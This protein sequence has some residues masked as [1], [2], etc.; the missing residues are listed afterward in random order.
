MAQTID[1]IEQVRAQL[2]PLA[3]VD[4]AADLDFAIVQSIPTALRRLAESTAISDAPHIRNYFQKIFVCAIIGNTASFANHL[5]AT[6]PMLLSV[7][8]AEVT[9]SL[10]THPFQYVGGRSL[11]TFSGSYDFGYY[12]VVDTDILIKP[13]TGR[14]ADLEGTNLGVLAP[15]VPV[16]ASVP[17]SLLPYLVSIIADLLSNVKIKHESRPLL[18]DSQS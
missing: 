9:N 14:E 15:Y 4:S 1:V 3:D 16:L 18:F 12:T 2:A 17:N 13:P 6:E 11:L 8:F 7:P 10:L 5:T